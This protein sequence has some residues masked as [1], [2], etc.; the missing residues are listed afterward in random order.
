M[1]KVLSIHSFAITRDVVL[2]NAKTGTIDTCFDDS[3]LV[4]ANNFGF[5]KQGEEYECK[6]K[7]FGEVLANAQEEAVLCKVIETDVR[8]GTKEMVKVMVEAD[9]YYIP[10]QKIENSLYQDE[11]YFRYTR[12]DLVAV[13]DIVH[14]DYCKNSI[15]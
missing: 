8:I 3:R 1:H 7:L 13:D 10:R 11:F 6:I 2:E 4:S 9:E 5:I 12:K 15:S 14:A